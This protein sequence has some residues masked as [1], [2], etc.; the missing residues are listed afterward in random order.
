MKIPESSSSVIYRAIAGGLAF[1]TL[2]HY[3]PSKR[4]RDEEITFSTRGAPSRTP[5]LP[6]TTHNPFQPVLTMRYKDVLQ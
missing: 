5:P 1:S 2:A 6:K 4:S 3:F